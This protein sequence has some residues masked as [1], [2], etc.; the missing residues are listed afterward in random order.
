MEDI[1]RKVDEDGQYVSGGIKPDIEAK[2]DENKPFSFR[3]FGDPVRDPQLK[4]A[5]EV[6]LGK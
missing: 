4:K 1:S 2:I 5:I 3:D 6:I